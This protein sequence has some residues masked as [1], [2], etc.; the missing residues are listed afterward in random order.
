[1]PSWTLFALI[2]AA[3]WSQPAA[4]QSE[5]P[6][7]NTVA[8]GGGVGFLASDNGTPD[9]AQTLQATTGN[10]DAFF[11]YY[12]MPRVSLR[13][14]YGWASPKFESPLAGSLR[15][16]HLTL[17]FI[18]NWELGRFR[19]FATIAGGAYFLT[20]RKTGGEPDDQ[21]NK[22][23]GLL[24]WGGEYYFR[25]FAVRSEM[26]VHILSEE[27]SLPEFNG[28]TLSGFTWT[29]GIKVPF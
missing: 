5:H 2:L 25:T 4:A 18:Y 7:E 10:V 17:G 6:R 28:K 24:G 9:V 1:M 11:E 26:N 3:L 16:H 29:F 22:P 19:P 21:V 23:G 15:R 8:I 12:S 13:V 20:R 14:M 27:K